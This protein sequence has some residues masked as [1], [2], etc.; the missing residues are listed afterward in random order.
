MKN[1]AS[2]A[3]ILSADKET[4]VEGSLSCSQKPDTGSQLESNVSGSHPHISLLLIT[5]LLV[6]SGRSVQ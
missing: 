6:R 5:L 2:K 1:N 4:V 3:N